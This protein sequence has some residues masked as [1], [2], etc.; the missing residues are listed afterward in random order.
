MF[1]SFNQV[2]RAYIGDMQSVDAGIP[3]YSPSMVSY[4]PTTLT[5]NSDTSHSFKH[6]AGRLVY[7]CSKDG[8]VHLSFVDED[9]SKDKDKDSEN[10]ADIADAVQSVLGM[11]L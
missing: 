3:G 9:A 11:I 2:V 10:V 7:I 8:P 6:W 1:S 4:Y 5:R